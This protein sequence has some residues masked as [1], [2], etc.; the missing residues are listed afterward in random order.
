M[1]AMVS[2]NRV[3]LGLALAWVGCA[4][5]KKDV[6]GSGDDRYDE[7]AA[8]DKGPARGEADSV[9]PEC[10][11]DG[12]GD[13]ILLDASSGARVACALVTLTR[14]ALDCQGGADCSGEV[15]FHGR[16]NRA[17][18]VALAAPV[19]DG[20]LA[21]AAEGFAPSYRA[22]GA[23]AAGK[24]LEIELA[25]AEGFWLKVVD[26]EGNYLQDVPVTFTQGSD[27]LAQLRTNVLANVFFAHRS[28]F[29]GDPVTVA[30]PGYKPVVVSGPADLGDDG[31]TVT[32]PK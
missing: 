22:V 10:G 26:G 28:P 9:R 4:T 19:K 17:G 31:H 27:A 2:G 3:A 14:E 23:T 6:T 24:P 13:V 32:L 21:V 25:P 29:S 7:T 8:P 12:K 5:A 18:E 11:P 16:A 1:R 15:V 20:R 30:A